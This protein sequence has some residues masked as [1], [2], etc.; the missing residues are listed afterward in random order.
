MTAA[1]VM[2]MAAN[3]SYLSGPAKNSSLL[4]RAGVACSRGASSST[5]AG[6]R[7]LTARSSATRVPG[8]VVVADR[9]SGRGGGCGV[10]W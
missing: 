5:T 7:A 6:S 1:L 3:P 4:P 9:A 10:A 2:P 8:P